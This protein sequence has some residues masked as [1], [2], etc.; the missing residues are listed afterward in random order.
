MELVVRCLII[1]DLFREALLFGKGAVH[2]SKAILGLLELFVVEIV[3][4]PIF[5]EGARLDRN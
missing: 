5:G 1:Q 3:L 4:R 2:P